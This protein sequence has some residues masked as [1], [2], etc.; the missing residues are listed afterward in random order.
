MSGNIGLGVGGEFDAIRSLLQR[1]GPLAQGIGD[2]AAVLDV[3]RDERLVVTTDAA[4]E[5]VHFRREWMTPEQIGWRAVAAAASDLAAMGAMPLGI[6]FALGIP[7]TWRTG[8]GALADGLGAACEAFAI[9]IVGGNLSAAGELSIV[10]TV[11]G[12]APAPVARGGA[13]PGDV[14]YVTGQLGGP[15]A[16]LTALYGGTEPAPAHLER[17]LRPSPRLA[18]GRWLADRGARAMIDISDGLAADL[19]HLAAASA[20]RIVVSVDDVPVMSG[21]DPVAAL[22]SGEEYELACALPADAQIDVNA[23]ERAFGLSLTRIGR[24][25]PGAAEVVLDREGTRVAPPRG[26]DH[27]SS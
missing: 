17:V 10:S 20:V 6:V 23:F 21:V 16:A 3:P 1:W 9:P 12:S 13:R 14:V 4:V 5:R 8:I 22:G 2:D 26:H 7:S 11:V 25:E 27:F 18:E 19:G 15:G 24:A